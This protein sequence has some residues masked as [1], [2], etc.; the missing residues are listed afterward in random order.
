MH[1]LVYQRTHWNND[2][3]HIHFDIGI[4]IYIDIDIHM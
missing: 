4:V 3:Y 1:N 2:E